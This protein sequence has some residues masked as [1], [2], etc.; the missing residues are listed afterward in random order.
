MNSQSL[1]KVFKVSPDVDP[2]TGRFAL[3]FKTNYDSSTVY[4]VPESRKKVVSK[5][6]TTPDYAFIVGTK[7]TSDELLSTGKNAEFVTQ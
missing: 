6:T 7:S 2:K 3:H 1:H 5:I 4:L